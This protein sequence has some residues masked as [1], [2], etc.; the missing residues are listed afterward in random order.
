MV[1]RILQIAVPFIWFGLVLGISFLETPL[2]FQ[3]PN[4]TIPLGLGI[5]RLVFFAL[6]KIEIILAVLLLISFVKAKPKNKIAAAAFRTVVVLLFLETVWLLPVLDARAVSIING[7]NV[8][9]SNLH[10]VYIV[11][12]ALKLVLLF[13]LGTILTKQNLKLEV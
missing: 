5:G 9:Q 7:E 10:L 2:K 1:F 6:N 4:I 13:V 11:F 8:Q 12:D 3:A